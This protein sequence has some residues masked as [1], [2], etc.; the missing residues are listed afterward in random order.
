MAY[1]PDDDYHIKQIV[2]MYHRACN[3]G[4]ASAWAA[5]HYFGEDAQYIP[6]QY[7]DKIPE[8][9]GKEV[10]LVDLSFTQR[11]IATII[12]TVKLLV[13]IDHHK[14]AI[15]ALQG[16]YV[17]VNSL[18]EL[19]Q[20]R[21]L[22]GMNFFAMLDKEHSGAVLTWQFFNNY[23]TADPDRGREVPEVL[24]YIQDY[25]LWRH[26]IPDAKPLNAWLIN[27]PLTISRFDKIVR[28]DNVIRQ[29][30][31][32]MGRMLMGYDEQIIR[33]VTRSYVQMVPV[34]KDMIPFLN[35]PHHLRNEIGDQLG[36]VHPYV[37]LYT[38]R[39]GKTIYSLRSSNPNYDVSL[40]SELNGGGGHAEAAAFAKDHG[41]L[42]LY[43]HSLIY[44]KPSLGLRL[45]TA[46]RV[47]LGKR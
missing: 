10:Y 3:D 1:L 22:T 41:L 44:G 2:V 25:D 42:E 15:E 36:K 19:M 9:T 39:D 38:E 18:Q 31:I 47:L 24:M 7:G 4:I 28:F 29:D 46:W 30:Y 14:S 32:E 26:E 5:Y 6:W 12:D 45:K 20:Q 16:T 43:K 35:A 8:L 34:G 40:I 27:G 11:E 17:P 21:E 33:G 37:V 23:Y 13:I